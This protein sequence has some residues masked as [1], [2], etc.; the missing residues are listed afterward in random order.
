MVIDNLFYILGV[1]TYFKYRSNSQ[2]LKDRRA[3]IQRQN[4]TNIAKV[5]NKVVSKIPA[6]QER[7]LWKGKGNGV[8]LLISLSTM[9][10]MEIFTQD[11][12]NAL[13]INYG[14]EPPGPNY[15]CYGCR[16][17]LSISHTLN[18]KKGG[19]VYTHKNDVREGVSNKDSKALIPLHVCNYPLV[20]LG[21]T[22]QG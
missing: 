5:I 18:C 3:D 8:W 14:M 12:R 19:L 11:C 22:V 10:G 13:F 1:W 7:R 4:I 9:N 20:H 16:D 6:Q 15:C 17:K 21:H 2:I